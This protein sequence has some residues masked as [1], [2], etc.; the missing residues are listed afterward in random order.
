MPNKLPPRDLEMEARSMEAFQNGDSTTI[1]Q[2]IFEL[3]AEAVKKF[4][5]DNPSIP[6]A[7]AIQE[8]VHELFIVPLKEKIAI[9]EKYSE[10]I[11]MM[12][13][14]QVVAVS[15][16]DLGGYSI[17]VK[18]GIASISTTYEDMSLADAIITAGKTSS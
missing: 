18:S 17:T 7:T 16:L 10:A 6:M 13:K 5:E 14:G 4:I 11:K 1:Q 2:R 12:E 8:A 15:V 3:R 9:L